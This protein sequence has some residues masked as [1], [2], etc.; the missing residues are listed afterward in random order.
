MTAP[1]PTLDPN[2]GYSDII[3]YYLGQWGLSSLAPVVT[4]L[5]QTGASSDQINLT[6]QQTPE[7]QARFAGNTA[8]IAAG[9][10][11]LD[12]ATYIATEEGYDQAARAYNLPAGMVTKAL[13]DQWI[14]GDV[15][16]SE[17][18]DRVKMAN[19]AYLNAPASAQQAWDQFYGTTGAGGAVAAI[20]DPN[21]AESV[22]QQQVNTAAIGGAAIQQGLYADQ[23]IA[24]QA[25]Q[26]GVSLAQAQK[27]YQDVAQRAAVNNS[28]SNRFSGQAPTPGQVASFGTTQ[29]TQA[30][31]LGDATQT[32]NQSTLYAEEQSQFT[33]H[34]GASDASGSPG[35]N[36]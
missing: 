22:I 9:L 2:A 3:N 14:G 34:G 18:A 19:D 10:A 20:L 16:V 29:D 13:T 35:A 23:S 30:T 7:W 15:S 32:R 11:P 12:P 27:A 8:R 1:D 33:G 17:V 24:S 28:I 26:Q 5:G 25:A 4:Q 21:T 6:L 31:L 36:Y